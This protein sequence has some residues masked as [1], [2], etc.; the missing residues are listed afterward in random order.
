MVSTTQLPQLRM[1]AFF[2]VFMAEQEDG[3]EWPVAEVLGMAGSLPATWSSW[4]FGDGRCCPHSN[5][6]EKGPTS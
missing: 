6:S 2:D 3:P 4:S 1:I 5:Q